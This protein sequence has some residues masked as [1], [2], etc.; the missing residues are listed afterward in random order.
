MNFTGAI[1][2]ISGARNVI[3]AVLAVSGPLLLLG[4]CT[5]AR[6]EKRACDAGRALATVKVERVDAAA[7]DAAAGERVADA[8]VIQSNEQELI[9]AIEV[10][11][12]DKP[13]AV[14]VAL[15]CERLRQAGTREAALPLVCRPA[16]GDGAKAGARP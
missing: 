7:K 9:D 2:A 12:D 4:H 11:P 5:G 3:V 8:L 13:D 6:S 1:S 10:I 15:G 14:R 16:G